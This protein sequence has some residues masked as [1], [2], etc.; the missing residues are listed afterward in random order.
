MRETSLSQEEIVKFEAIAEDWWNPSGKFKPLHDLTP[1]RIDYIKNL[2]N[3]HFKINSI[4]NLKIL[5]VGCGGGLISEPLARLKAKVTAIDASPLNIS[6][7]KN[8]ASISGLEI[9]YKNILVEELALKEQ[10]F[11]VIIALEI[12]EHVENVGFFI[13]TCCKLLEKNGIIIFSTMNKTIK[14]FLESIIAAEYILK[15]LPIG[16]HKWSKFIKP[17]TINTIMIQEK[18]KLI[19]LQGI[20]FSPL[21]RTWSF[22]SNISNN[23]FIAYSI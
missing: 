9:D 4:D 14:S 2:L 12:L 22:S 10:K 1:L 17:S 13:K 20:S 7:A 8:H 11:Q 5:D 16:T 21:S 3:K 6:I 23:Y 18:A 19:D 15:W